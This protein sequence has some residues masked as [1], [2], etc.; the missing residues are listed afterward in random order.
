MRT[1]PAGP[2]VTVPDGVLLSLVDEL[3][4]EGRYAEST[5]SGLNDVVSR[6][7]RFCVSHDAC[8]LPASESTL[9]A[10]LES[11]RPALAWSYAKAQ[12][13]MIMVSHVLAGL[14]QPASPLLRVYLQALQRDPASPQKQRK[15]SSLTEAD[16]ERMV[17]QLGTSMTLAGSEHPARA[18]V[19]RAVAGYARAG[20]PDWATVASL[21]TPSSGLVTP[22]DVKARG[23]NLRAGLRRAGRRSG[24]DVRTLGDVEALTESDYNLLLSHCDEAHA[25][26]LRDWTYVVLGIS[27]GL[28]HISLAHL[29]IADVRKVDDGYVAVFRRARLPAGQV[30]T[31]HFRHL[32]GQPQT[33]ADALCP[34]C[35]IERQLDVCGRQGRTSGPLLATY[36]RGSWRPMTRQNGRLRVLSAYGDLSESGQRRIA[37][38]SFRSTAA[39]WAFKA[40]LTIAE[41]AEFVTNHRDTATCYIYIR[42]DGNEA[43]VGPRY[44]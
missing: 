32:D 14:P 12:L 4:S 20:T 2:S 29:D 3:A 13:R 41:I 37:T 31:K 33:C 42:P 30:L 27:G 40:G 25:R 18:Q 28:R 16:V 22:D 11:Q 6:F 36:Y 19:L 10:F 8:P 7:E 43:P 26:N 21:V 24:L 9:L 23:A 35:A 5:L 1:P 44:V 17:G 39:T 15:V 34:A 38:R